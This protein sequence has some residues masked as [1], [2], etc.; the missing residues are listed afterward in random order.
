MNC[1]CASNKASPQMKCI[2]P[3]EEMEMRSISLYCDA[4]TPEKG[5]S[6][7][8]WCCLSISLVIIL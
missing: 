8:M 4:M 1:L 7:H 2:I 6:F 5:W 3:Q